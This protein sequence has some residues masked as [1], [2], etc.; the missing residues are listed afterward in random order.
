MK[1]MNVQRSVCSNKDIHTDFQIKLPTRMSKQLLCYLAT[2]TPQDPVNSSY[3]SEC[4]CPLIVPWD[5][6][7]FSKHQ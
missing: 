3:Y 4:K 5:N 1:K 7:N 2:K 6:L